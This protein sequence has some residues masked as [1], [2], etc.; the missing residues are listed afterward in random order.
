MYHLSTG[1]HAAFRDPVSDRLFVLDGA[2]VRRWGAGAAMT[3]TFRSKL[4]QTP[5]PEVMRAVE[6]IAKGYP[7]NVKVWA[8]GTLVLDQAVTSDDVVRPSITKRADQFQV[9]VSSA[10][11]VVAVRLASSVDE[12]RS[13]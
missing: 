9:E 12:L 7:V 11:R 2:N 3:A 6:V 10:A 1:Y 5:A 8:D 4:I 13:A